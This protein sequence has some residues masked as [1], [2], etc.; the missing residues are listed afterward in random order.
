MKAR[1]RHKR[2]EGR[3]IPKQEIQ[4]KYNPPEYAFKEVRQILSLLAALR[5]SIQQQQHGRD[6]DG[7]ESAAVSP[8]FMSE[9]TASFE[10]LSPVVCSF[11]ASAVPLLFLSD[12]ALYP[13]LNFSIL[14]HAAL[15][16]LLHDPCLPFTL[17]ASRQPLLGSDGIVSRLLL[18]SSAATAGRQRGFLMLVLQR[19]LRASRC[20]G[21]CGPNASVPFN[22]RQQTHAASSAKTAA[23]R[24]A[25]TAAGAAAPHA[26]LPPPANLALALLP[27]LTLRARTAALDLRVL[28]CLCISTAAPTCLHACSWWRPHDAF[29]LLAKRAATPPLAAGRGALGGPPP[30]MQQGTSGLL[31]LATVNARLLLQRFGI[32]LWINAQLEAL[33]VSLNKQTTGSMK[34]QAAGDR[35]S[36]AAMLRCPIPMPCLR[37]AAADCGDSSSHSRCSSSNSRSSPCGDACSL[38]S[39][40]PCSRDP[41]S[42]IRA[43]DAARVL[44]MMQGLT[45]LFWSLVT[46]ATL[47]PPLSEAPAAYPAFSSSNTSSDKS[48]SKNNSSSS[49]GS[50]HEGLL[51]K[52]SCPLSRSLLSLTLQARKQLFS[53]RPRDEGEETTPKHAEAAYQL[54]LSLLS[55]VQTLARA[56]FAVAAASCQIIKLK[57]EGC[58]VVASP[59][60]HD[61]C[62]PNLAADL[63]QA[64][65]A[66]ASTLWAVITCSEALGLL[67]GHSTEGRGERE[68]L[69]LQQ[70][71]LHASACAAD[72]FRLCGWAV[73]VNRELQDAHAARK[74]LAACRSKLEQGAFVSPQVRLNSMVF[75]ALST[76]GVAATESCCGCSGAWSACSGSCMQRQRRQALMHALLRLQATCGGDTFLRELC[77]AAA[78]LQPN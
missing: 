1:K 57:C 71:Q 53:L 8:V 65:S 16:L 13:V 11:A 6:M 75:A 70:H 74:D 48:S 22:L 20:I 9:D 41:P 69:L 76:H 26:L 67:R 29:K 19:A 45:R 50:G 47:T 77:A 43:A 34:R 60:M 63:Q 54:H 44:P 5:A 59:R 39:S 38:G 28:E 66:C 7:G 4:Q 42:G 73:A 27:Q 78:E 72:V 36:F 2:R 25:A 10:A 24:T 52:A 61:A 14:K 32:L 3:R 15:S 68:S 12:D 17:A 21:S 35:D 58:F 56:W 31:P 30:T 33:L 62:S 18:S 55:A 23:A 40:T 64:S 37:G 51:A 49:S 46:A